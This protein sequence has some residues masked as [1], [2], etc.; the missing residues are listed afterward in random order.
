MRTPGLLFTASLIAP[1]AAAQPAAAQPAPP[2]VI[3]PDLAADPRVLGDVRKYFIFHQQGTSLDQARAD[4]GYCSRYTMLAGG[5]VFPAF[6]PL[7]N[8]PGSANPVTYDFGGQYGLTGAIIGAMIAGPLERG[9]KQM[10]MMRCMLPRGYARYRISEELWKE[11]NGKDRLAAI[12]VQAR[13]ATGPV[14]P[15][16][17]VLP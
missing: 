7:D 17:R 5:V 16:P 4:F 1:P 8:R 9:K 13:L 12:E 3:V 14:P 6:I 11:I 10:A 15:T 2:V